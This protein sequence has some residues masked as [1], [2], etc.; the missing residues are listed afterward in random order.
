MIVFSAFGFLIREHATGRVHPCERHSVLQEDSHLSGSSDG[1]EDD[2][3][4]DDADD[5]DDDGDDDDA[6]ARK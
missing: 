2:D 3:D 6:V 4:D 1:G 5:D